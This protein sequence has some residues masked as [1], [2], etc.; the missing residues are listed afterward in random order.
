MGLVGVMYLVFED[1]ILGKTKKP[2]TD[3]SLSRTI[4]GVQV[5]L[6]EILKAQMLIFLKLGFI[7][8]AMVVTRASVTSLQSKQGLPLGTQVMGWLVLSKLLESRSPAFIDAS[9]CI[10]HGSIPPP[11]GSS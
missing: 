10:P 4:F 6:R 3:F 8:L 2:A 11:F 9:S 5:K 1:R 7:P